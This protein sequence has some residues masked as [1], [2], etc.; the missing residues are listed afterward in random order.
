MRRDISTN[1]FVNPDGPTLR[2]AIARRRALIW[3][4]GVLLVAF[5]GTITAALNV[6]FSTYSPQI[7]VSTVELL[8]LQSL[9]DF[10]DNPALPGWK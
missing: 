6:S 2:G 10:T 8:S 5:L 3:I 9:S 1:T 7:T 4:N